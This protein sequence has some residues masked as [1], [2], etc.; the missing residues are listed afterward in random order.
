ME[1]QCIQDICELTGY[2]RGALPFR[3]L[4]VPISARK[5]SI[6]DCEMLVEKMATKVRTWSTRNISYAGRV[7]LVNSVL[8]QVHSYW[9]SIFILPKKVLVNIIGICRSFLWEG[10][11]NSTKMALVAWDIV[12]RPKQQGG[13]GITDCIIW[14]EAAMVKYVWNITKKEDN[15]WVKWVNHVYIKDQSWRQYVPPNDSCWYWK[16]IC[17]IRDKF[18]AGFVNNGWLTQ[19]ENILKLLTKEQLLK[20]KISQDSGC[21]ICGNQVETVEHLFFECKLLE[22]CLRRMVVWMQRG[23]TKHDLKGIWRRITRGVHGKNCREFIT[24]VIA[25]LIY[26]IWWAR[27]EA[28]WNQRVPTPRSI[29]VQIQQECKARIAQLINKKSSRKERE[30]IDQLYRKQ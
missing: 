9:A 18:A 25:A 27:N 24:A 16:K 28:L 29:C 11:G 13:L 15:L 22:E 5:L 14:N 21:L 10:K 4:G 1:E 19:G 7:M 17:T 20:L 12:C 8:M 23:T 6:T 30:W 3:Y 26:K 2:Q